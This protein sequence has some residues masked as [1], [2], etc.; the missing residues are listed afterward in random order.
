MSFLDNLKNA[1]WGLGGYKYMGSQPSQPSTQE[2][3]NQELAR[4]QQQ[5]QNAP[6]MTAP[7][8][9]ATGILDMMNPNV[10]YPKAPGAPFSTP[11]PPRTIDPQEQL[12]RQIQ[13]LLGRPQQNMPAFQPIQMPAF[14][15]NRYKRQAEESVNAQFYPIINE[16]RAQQGATQ[17]R[18]TGNKAAVGR[19]YG[20]MA[21]SFLQDLATSNKTYDTAQA[22]SQNL[23]KDERDRIAA[24]YAADAA[25]QRAAARK[26]G[27]QALDQGAEQAISQ[28]NADKNFAQQMGSQQMQSSQ[29]VMEQQ[30]QAAGTYDRAMRGATQ[31]EGAEVQQDIGRQLEDYM[32]QSNANLSSVQSQRAGSIQDLMAQL[33][34]AGYQRDV[35]NTQFGYQQQRDYIGDQNALYDRDLNT[36]MKQ[37]E[38]A[39]QL[40]QLQGQGQG[41][42]TDKL[43]PWQSTAAFAE[44]LRPGQGSD[45]V[46][47]IQGAMNERPEIYARSKDD[48]VPMTSALFAKL[49]AD[50][51]SAQ[52]LDR[53]AVMMAAQEIYRLLYGIG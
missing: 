32:S 48:P 26:L 1:I 39:Q 25:A 33:A 52:G 11:Q 22:Q 2:R 53:N 14:D 43:N 27:I 49:V 8:K 12:L 34:N 3:I 50:S 31:A 5:K 4:I 20:A 13:D 35:A 10:I 15:P 28:Q 41:Q 42:S 29:N 19:E 38:I 24:G 6:V 17:K 9:P 45:I 23:Y 44:S 40:A 36:K 18:A 37:L 30:Q 21:N 16:I 51:Q 7:F 46:G 47:A